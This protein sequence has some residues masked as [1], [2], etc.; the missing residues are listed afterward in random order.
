MRPIWEHEAHGPICRPGLLTCLSF[1][2]DK[3]PGGLQYSLQPIA[4][5]HEGLVENALAIAAIP[6]RRVEIE[7]FRAIGLQTAR[8]PPALTTAAR[9]VSNVPLPGAT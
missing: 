9:E 6:C 1:F 4:I 5:N 3:T 7:V 8:A 2:P